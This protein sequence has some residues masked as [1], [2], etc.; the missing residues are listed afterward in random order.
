[1]NMTKTI[2]LDV[3][4]VLMD[5]S[6][7]A[8]F[9]EKYPTDWK[10]FLSEEEVIKDV[11]TAFHFMSS[12]PYTPHGGDKFI[13]TGRPERL[14]EITKEQVYASDSITVPPMLMRPDDM[15]I[16]APELKVMQLRVLKL[17]YDV[18]PQDIV[19]FDDSPE[20]LKAL[21]KHGVQCVLVTADEHRFECVSYG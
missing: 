11:P 4:G 5:N 10:S 12:V 18:D 9:I 15:F 19:W 2:V 17:D 14:R 6:H 3:D 13:I 16:P 21:A 8:H 7:R 1:M 20:V